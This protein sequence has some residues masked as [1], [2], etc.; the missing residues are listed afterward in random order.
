M[1]ILKMYPTSLNENYL[2]LVTKALKDGGTVI[3]PTDSLYAIGCDASNGH[4]V[5]KICRLKNVDP[6]RST[7]SIIC[8]DISQ[9]AEYARIDNKAFKILKEYLPGPFTFI[10]PTS[11]ALPKVFKGR[12]EVGVRI[13][14][15][16]IAREIARRLES[17]LLTTSVEIP[18][19]ETADA[20]FAESIAA[21]YED[22]AEIVID[23]G[24]GAGTPSTVVDVT[25]SSSPV[26]VRQG[27]GVF[28]Q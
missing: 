19:D 26:I 28:D 9:A 21:H 27:L 3:Y 4:A 24:E 25:D 20:R 23:G 14:D 1:T 6:R 8:S 12:K 11:P 15:N 5:E 10:L 2:E 13:P 22:I 7:L 17:P 18:G 16:N